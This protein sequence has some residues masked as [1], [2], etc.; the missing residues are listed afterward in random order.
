MKPETCETCRYWLGMYD[1]AEVGFC[2]RYPPIVVGMGIAANAPW[3][4]TVP[5][6]WCG[7]YSRKGAK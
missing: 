7:E 1:D 3:P 4:K 2:R 5:G 6:D